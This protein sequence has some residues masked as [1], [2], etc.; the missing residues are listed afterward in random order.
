MTVTVGAG[1][2][3][4]VSESRRRLGR[5]PRQPPRRRAFRDHWHYARRLGVRLELAKQAQARAMAQGHSN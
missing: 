4:A 5:W 2:P 3:V 1:P